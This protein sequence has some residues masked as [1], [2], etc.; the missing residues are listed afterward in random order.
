MRY[1]SSTQV[2][3]NSQLPHFACTSRILSFKAILNGLIP[4]RLPCFCVQSSVEGLPTLQQP[5][6]HRRLANVLM[7]NAAE[8]GSVHQ[9]LSTTM[10]CKAHRIQG[11][12]LASSHI[13]S[14]STWPAHICHEKIH[15]AHSTFAAEWDPGCGCPPE[16]P[17]SSYQNHSAAS[18]QIKQHLNFAD[19]ATTN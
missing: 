17:R 16:G 7:G 15:L 12:W 19:M 1:C 10:V 8:Q 4:H 9:G 2:K 3:G 14:E 11:T 18:I 13:S 5:T 6:H